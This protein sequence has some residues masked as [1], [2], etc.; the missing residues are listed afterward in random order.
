M[1]RLL[2]SRHSSDRRGSHLALELLFFT[3]ADHHAVS[4][5]IQEE[6]R[7]RIDLI[8]LHGEGAG[9]SIHR[10]AAP[11]GRDHGVAARRQGYALENRSKII[12][13]KNA[14]EITRTIAAQLTGNVFLRWT[15]QV[16]AKIGAAEINRII[17]RH[18]VKPKGSPGLRLGH[19]AGHEVSADID[20]FNRS[21]GGLIE[22]QRKR[23]NR[24]GK[25]G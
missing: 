4:V 17:T 8:G 3:D 24:R 22:G 15:A 25:R 13:I 14:G 12:D 1:I 11:A 5:S 6:H 20:E 21:I 7:T 23:E 10:G 9:R 18:G 16:A 2:R 19:S